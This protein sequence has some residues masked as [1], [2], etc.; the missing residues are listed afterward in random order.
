MENFIYALIQS[1]HNLGAV[2][3]VAAPALMLFRFQT[4]LNL[5]KIIIRVI[6]FAW[7]LQLLSGAAFGLS[8]YQFYGEI[9][10]ID[11]IAFIALIIKLS[12]AIT[13]VMMC[14]YL[15]VS[16]RGNNKALRFQ[17]FWWM[18]LSFGLSA[19]LSAAFLRWYG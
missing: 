2:V 19:L 14:I 12:C 16:I 18:L 15:W 5:N 1:L 8:S 10:D 6:F 11:G 7:S 17:C 4:K 9:P 13:S 3:V